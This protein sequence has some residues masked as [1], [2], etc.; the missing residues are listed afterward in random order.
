MF[1]FHHVNA[2]EAGADVVL[3]FVRYDDPLVIDE[4][5]LDRLRRAGSRLALGRLTR[6]RIAPRGDA[7]EEPLAAATF[8]FPRI[9][10][11]Q[12][13]NARYRFVHGAAIATPGGFFDRLV[14]CDLARGTQAVWQ[15]PG[16]H[17]GEP[18]FVAAPQGQREDLGV[19]LSVVLDAR[20]QRS[21][22]LVLDAAAF[23]EIARA[24]LPHA[25]PFGFHG[26][27]VAK[28]IEAT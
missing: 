15:Q 19:V 5:M 13:G 21:F 2:F 23:A 20:A 22:L 1:A 12:R 26:G 4:L 14:K 17:P 7:V 18:V 25:L 9:D 10:E 8:E 11:R 3:D 27:Y 28:A 6:L 24:E 16:C